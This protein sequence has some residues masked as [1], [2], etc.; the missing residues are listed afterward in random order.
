MLPLTDV[1]RGQPKPVVPRYLPHEDLTEGIAK[2]AQFVKDDESRQ[3]LSTAAEQAS[4]QLA[5]VGEFE[6]GKIGRAGTLAVGEVTAA[7]QVAAD[8]P[9]NVW[10]LM[11]N[12]PESAAPAA[13]EIK[14]AAKPRVVLSNTGPPNKKKKPKPKVADAE[15]NSSSSSQPKE[16]DGDSKSSRAS[17]S[18][19][20]KRS[21]AGSLKGGS[22]PKKAR[23]DNDGKDSAGEDAEM[24]SESK[25]GNKQSRKVSSKGGRASASSSSSNSAPAA[26][27]DDDDAAMAAGSSAEFEGNRRSQRRRPAKPAVVDASKDKE[28][29][30]G[31]R[32]DIALSGDPTDRDCRAVRD[33]AGRAR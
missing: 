18:S 17:G 14:S 27:S 28:F 15:S 33:R 22:K 31:S 26:G 12:V 24:A 10:S 29:A 25:A 20:A 23:P 6:R 2:C 32:N 9:P 13:S 19:R 4:W 5:S 1:P 11:A 21:N 16:A 30:E 3:W 8:L 7:V